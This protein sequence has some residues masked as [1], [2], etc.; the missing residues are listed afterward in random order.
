MLV[1]QSATWVGIFYIMT[2]NSKP[3]RTTDPV[4]EHHDVTPKCVFG[5]YD[6]YHLPNDLTKHTNHN[7][8]FT[9]IGGWFN[10]EMWP[11]APLLGA[12]SH[13]WIINVH[14]VACG[15]LPVDVTCYSTCTLIILVPRGYDRVGLPGWVYP[16]KHTLGICRVNLSAL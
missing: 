2:G 7:V 15:S 5:H 12:F 3:W 16:V 14:V 11:F 4:P 1:G 9:T 13:L 10:L 6:I 8:P